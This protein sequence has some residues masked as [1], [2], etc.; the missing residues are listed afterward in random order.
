[1]AFGAGFWDFFWLPSV[2]V[3]AFLGGGEKGV[4]SSILDSS[5]VDSSFLWSVTSFGVS[6]SIKKVSRMGF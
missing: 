3:G 2:F 5:S 4:T 6:G 1:V